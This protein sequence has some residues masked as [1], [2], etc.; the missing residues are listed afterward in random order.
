[1][2]HFDILLLQTPQDLLKTALEA[3]AGDRFAGPGTFPGAPGRALH[4][5]LVDNF[6]KGLD[7][8]AKGL[9]HGLISCEKEQALH[10]K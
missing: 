6:A 5:P 3:G 7:N 1:M 8:F 2:G 10:P 4:L 9:H